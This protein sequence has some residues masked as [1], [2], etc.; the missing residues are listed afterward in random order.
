MH[1][2]LVLTA[3]LCNRPKNNSPSH[4]LLVQRNRPSLHKLEA[5]KTVVFR[6]AFALVVY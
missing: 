2:Q 3:M 4:V 5:K 1:E 6:Q